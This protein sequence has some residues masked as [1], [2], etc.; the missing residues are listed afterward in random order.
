MVRAA[1]T[2][3]SSIITPTGEVTESLPPLVEGYILDEVYMIS[4]NTLYT[5]VGNILILIA[6]V[7]VIALFLWPAAGK[8]SGEAAHDDSN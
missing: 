2:G 8:K 5:M 4:D 6:G 3:I 7:Y 1:N